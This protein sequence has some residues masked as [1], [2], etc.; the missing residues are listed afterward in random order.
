MVSSAPPAL[1][2]RAGETSLSYR[3]AP[4][5]R[6]A[7]P[8]EWPDEY[9]VPAWVHPYSRKYLQGRGLTKEEVED[10]RLHY[11]EAGYWRNRILI[12]IYDGERLLAFQG[13]IADDTYQGKDRYLT[14]GPRPLYVPWEP[15][16]TS[17]LCVVEGPFDVFSVNRVVRTVG[18]LGITPSWRTL[19]EIVSLVQFYKFS[20]TVVWFDRG[21]L[22]EGHNMAIK[23]RRS[24]SNVEVLSCDDSKDPGG[25]P[26]EQIRELLGREGYLD[27]KTHHA[28]EGGL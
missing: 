17:T 9:A 15:P 1:K 22:E 23:L 28:G 12:P 18:T 8:V 7:R 2:R 24:I 14:S 19:T 4:N 27:S 11:A 25:M 21:A 5:E 10:Y 26:T 20:K 3:E 13:R 16:V 6:P